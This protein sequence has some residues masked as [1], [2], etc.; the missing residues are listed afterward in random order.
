MRVA[1]SPVGTPTARSCPVAE[2]DLP[3]SAVVQGLE[4]SR[5]DVIQHQLLQAQLTH[6]TVSLRF[7]LLQLFQAPRLI[8]V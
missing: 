3:H 8:G 6:Q 2:H 4:V 7:L 5:G 1:D